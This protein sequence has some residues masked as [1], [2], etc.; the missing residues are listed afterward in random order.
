MKSFVV[1]RD[2]EIDDI[3]IDERSSVGNACR[4]MLESFVF[5]E[6]SDQTMKLP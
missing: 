3:S 4:W 2:I 6:V 1:E 5:C